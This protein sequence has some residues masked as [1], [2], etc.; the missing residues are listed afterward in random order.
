MSIYKYTAKNKYGESI[1]GKV[2]AQ[3]KQQAAAALIDRGL[4]VISIQPLADSSFAFIRNLFFGIKQTDVVNLTRQLATMINAGLPL[5]TALTI[6]QDQSKPQ[7]AR[8]VNKLL[9]D[10]EGGDTFAEA[11]K[12]HP[13]VF[14]RVYIQL[15]RAGEVGGL[16]DDIL[17]RLALNLEKDKDFKAKT[18]GAMIYPIIVILA[19]VVVGFI[20]MIFVIPKLTEMYKDFDAQL[21]FATRILIATSNFMTQFWWLILMLMVGGSV[22]LRA[23]SKT[24]LGEKTIDKWLM[25]IPIYGQLREKIILTEFARTMSLL[26]GSGVPLLEAMEIVGQAMSS[27]MYRDV[28]LD[29]RDDVEKGVQLSNALAKYEIMPP[30][31]PEMIA[32]GEETGKMDEIL[33]KLSEYYEKESEYAVKNL[34]TAMEPLI[35]IV[36]GVGVGLMVIAV[37]MPIYNLTNQF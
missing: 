22:G 20:M 5:A 1:N 24:D 10:V 27:R 17:D 30:I 32:V 12:R 37:I 21:P 9:K 36:L 7:L 2:E 19:M 11:L 34:T 18:K 33:L 26:M 14:S 25:K 31:L 28:V 4:L 23:W 13:D 8:L 15:V 3:T 6:L 16:L 35:M 29:S